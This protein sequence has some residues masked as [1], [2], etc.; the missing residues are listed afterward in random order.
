MDINSG[1]WRY[2]EHRGDRL[3]KSEVH[4]SALS[5]EAR[6][7]NIDLPPERRW[8]PM[9]K[10]QPGRFYGDY[11]YGFLLGVCNDLVRTLAQARA[12]DDERRVVL[13]SF[14]AMLQADDPDRTMKEG[15]FLILDIGDKYDVHFYYAD[16]E[17]RLRKMRSEQQTQPRVP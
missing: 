5:Q 3:V 6:R 8:K 10:S 7:L 12:P 13:E 9:A 11:A 17:E 15:R 2:Q 14:L 16:V 1:D 4:E